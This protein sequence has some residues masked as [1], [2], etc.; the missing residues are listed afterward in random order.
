[1]SRL[2]R[3][4]IATRDGYCL[5]LLSEQEAAEL[6]AE[7]D[8]QYRLLR[9]ERAE[10]GAKMPPFPVAS[11]VFHVRKIDNIAALTIVAF[12]DG[13][14]VGALPLLLGSATE[15][16]DFLAGRATLAEVRQR[17]TFVRDETVTFFED[18]LAARLG[19]ETEQSWRRGELSRAELLGRVPLPSGGATAAVKSGRRS[20]TE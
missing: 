15:V 16:G 9:N 13:K 11:A 1:M 6:G 17:R 7:E 5:V 10:I 18:M 14:E 8:I 2:P 3:N 19:S 12:V 4:P 20:S